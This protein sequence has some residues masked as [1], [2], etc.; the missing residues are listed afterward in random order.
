MF[1]GADDWSLPA[2]FTLRFLEETT[3]INTDSTELN[4]MLYLNLQFRRIFSI[5]LSE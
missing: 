5:I 2:D 3:T 4:L 1:G